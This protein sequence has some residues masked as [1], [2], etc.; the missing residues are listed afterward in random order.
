[1]NI[2]FTV[3]IQLKQMFI[4]KL[5]LLSYEKSKNFNVSIQ[6]IILSLINTPSPK[7]DATGELLKLSCFVINCNY[8]EKVIHLGENSCCKPECRQRRV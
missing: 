4:F 1:M 2:L 3:A 7:V 8:L 6:S 5:S